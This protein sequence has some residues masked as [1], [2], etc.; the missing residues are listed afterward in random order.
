MTLNQLRYFQTL[1]KTE[2]FRKAA[3]MLYI[4]QPS[5]SKAI[6]QLEAEFGTVLFEKNGRNVHLSEAGRTFLPY[7]DQA[8]SKIDQGAE[9][10]RNFTGEKERVS[11]GCVAPALIPYLAPM[12][13]AYQDMLQRELQCRT[14]VG[15]SENLLK[16]LLAGQHDVVFCSYVEGVKK[17]QFTKVCEFPFFVVVQKGS[18][19]ACKSSIRPEELNNYPLL[20]TNASAYSRMIHEMLDYYHVNTITAGLSNDEVG[21]LGMVEAGLGAFITTDYPQVHSEN[22]VLVPL[23]QTHFSRAIY[24]AIREDQKLSPHVQ[25]LVDFVYSSR[26]SSMIKT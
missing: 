9:V 14:E 10:L 17:V 15:M 1:A 7:V 16:D 11:I 8:L 24:M 3:D 13:K 20:F 22:T 6:A 5:L 19:F 26:V 25:G 2:H 18:K 12:I 21:L 4:S 23:E